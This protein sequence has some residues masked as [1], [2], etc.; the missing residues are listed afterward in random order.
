MQITG[1]FI[2]P[3]WSFSYCGKPRPSLFVYDNFVFLHTWANTFFLLFPF[4]FCGLLRLMNKLFNKNDKIR[5]VL[6]A[7][8]QSRT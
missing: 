2:G 1:A 8:S 3:Q 4:P 6:G 7:Q 5:L